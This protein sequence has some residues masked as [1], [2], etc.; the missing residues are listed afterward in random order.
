MSKSQLFIPD[1]I[2]VGFQ[3]REGTY[4]GLLAYIIYWDKKGK[5]RQEHSW[6][7]WRHKPEEIRQRRY[8][9]ETREYE[10]EE[11]PYGDKV[12][13]K[14]FDNVPTEGFV[15]NKKAGGYST[16]WNHRQTYCR[17][18]D[19]RGYEFEISVENLLYILE[20]TNSIIGK[21][22]EG[23]FVYSWDGKNVVLLPTNSKEYKESKE[24]TDLQDKKIGRKD[25]EVGC[26]YETKK[27]EVLT[28]L[29]RF[30]Y[31]VG[32]YSR[33]VG[34]NYYTVKPVKQHIFVDDNGRYHPHKGFTK[35]A[36]R[37]T[38]E[39]VENY[40]DLLEAYLTSAYGDRAKELKAVK[41]DKLKFK[42]L[43][44]VDGWYEN[45][46]EG[47]YSKVGDGYRG[48]NVRAEFHYEGA[49]NERKKIFKGFETSNDSYSYNFN[50]SE[51][52]RDWVRE[53]RGYNC[54]WGRKNYTPKKDIEAGTYYELYVVL[55]GGKEYKLKD[56]YSKI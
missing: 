26:V 24:F 34:D 5:L 7:G 38:T 2:N 54:G 43:D 8:N 30:D 40:S 1:R 46:V 3:E 35:L 39:A 52:R 9:W 19:P 16:G 53:S 44:K 28:Y 49:H 37:V 51:L 17:V 18:Y 29:G 25:M 15:L 41:V 45:V 14:A 4:S 13:P 10:G 50:G 23:E 33:G 22:L 47:V 31:M 12:A 36:K 48:F 20:C 55:E 27:Q 42:D 11:V 32:S 56:Y 21:G 6:D